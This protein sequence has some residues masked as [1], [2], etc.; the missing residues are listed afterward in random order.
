MFQ[1]YQHRRFRTKNRDTQSENER[2]QANLGKHLDQE[3]RSHSN[4]H[5][6]QPVPQAKAAD[7]DADV[8]QPKDGREQDRPAHHRADE[9]LA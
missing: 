6:V 1:E 3:V 5:D 4:A 2:E 8:H 9:E 7:P